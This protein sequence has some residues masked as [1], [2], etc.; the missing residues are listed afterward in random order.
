MG[1]NVAQSDGNEQ[2][3]MKISFVNTD[4][5]TTTYIDSTRFWVSND[6]ADGVSYNTAIQGVISGSYLA[7][8]DTL[9][10]VD[11]FGNYV[12]DFFSVTNDSLVISV[13][14][15]TTVGYFTKN[16]AV[17]SALAFITGTSTKFIAKSDG[18]GNSYTARANYGA[19]TTGVLSQPIDFTGSVKAD[20]INNDRL[21]SALYLGNAATANVTHTP[22]TLGLKFNKSASSTLATDD[23][24]T[25][26]VRVYGAGSA[27]YG[28]GTYF[29]KGMTRSTTIKRVLKAS[30]ASKLIGTLT[31]A[32]GSQAIVNGNTV[33]GLSVTVKDIFGDAFNAQT[34]GSSSL[35]SV[36]FKFEYSKK[37]TVDA[38]ITGQLQAGT[39]AA[40]S[41]KTIPKA[42]L[43]GAGV[44]A[45]NSASPYGS[46]LYSGATSSTG[47]YSITAKYIGMTS[48]GTTA[49]T[50]ARDSIDIIAYAKTNGTADTIRIKVTPGSPVYF[51]LDSLSAKL[52]TTTLVQGAQFP[53]S[54]PIFA[55]D[56][57]YNRITNLNL[58]YNTTFLDN[59]T[60]QSTAMKSINFKIDGRDPL[61]YAA[62]TKTDSIRI[63]S[64]GPIAGTRTGKG[65]GA[66]ALSDSSKIW[67][68]TQARSDSSRLNLG[69]TGA[70]PMGMRLN[71]TGSNYRISM[72]WNPADVGQT[73]AERSQDLGLF[74]LSAASAIDSVITVTQATTA[75]AGK[76]DT[77]VVSF[78]I[79]T[80]SSQSIGPNQADSLLFIQFVNMTSAAGIPS[81]INKANV[82]ISVDGTNYYTA[83]GVTQGTDNPDSIWVATP[84]LADAGTSNATVYVKIEGFVSPTIADTT[85]YYQVVVS[86]ESAPIKSHKY[87]TVVANSFAS[88]KILSPNATKSVT[89]P[90][91]LSQVNTTSLTDTLKAG[92]AA[93]FQIYTGDA[94]GNAVNIGSAATQ[95]LVVKHVDSTVTG[96]ILKV[97][98]TFDG[99]ALTTK[100]HAWYDTVTVKID[101]NSAGSYKLIDSLLVTPAMS[102]NYYIVVTDTNA[103]PDAMDSVMVHV[104]TTLAGTVALNPDTTVQ[105]ARST[106]LPTLTVTLR[107]TMGNLLADTLVTMKEQ[108]GDAAG[109]F[110][111]INDSTLSAVTDSVGVKASASGIATAIYKAG[112]GD[113]VSVKVWVLNSTKVTA[114]YY[115]AR[116]TLVSAGE[117][118]DINF[119][120]VPDS[121]V[122]DTTNA[123]TITVDLL[124]GEKVKKAYLT[125]YVSTL[126]LGTDMKFVESD[127]IMTL[128]ADSSNVSPAADSVRWTASIA[129]IKTVGT[130]IGYTVSAI[131]N[132]D[133]TTTSAM[134]HFIIA[135]K[136]GKRNISTSAV[137]VA[138]VMRSVYLVAGV[139]P[140]ASVTAVDYLGLDLDQSGDFDTPDLTAILAI[141]RG[142]GTLLASAGEQQAV[143]AKV[144]L[145]YV[146]TDKSNANLSVNLENSGSLNVA[147]LRIKYDT[148]KFVLGE[149]VATDR[150]KDVSVVT[151]NN[152]A[153][154]VYSIV[155]VNVNG[156]A[157]FKG[158]GA[159][160]TIPV[161]AVGDKFDGT[162]EISLLKAGFDDN[163]AA[164]LDRNVLSPKAVLPKAYALSQNYPNPFNPSTT[165]AFDVPE[166]KE[167]SV[168]LN[169]Y[170]MRGQLVRTLVS[171][172]KSEGSYQIQW[173]GDDNYGRKVS[174]GVYFYRIVAGEFSQTRKMV[175]LK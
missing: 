40:N 168:R 134:G 142:T 129:A 154:G 47:A 147:V 25:F 127:A 92:V 46:W 91:W 144:D 139:V 18:S 105:G 88:I 143:T 76:T 162:G 150:L 122:A 156:R 69:G 15:S 50:T 66:S 115:V 49:D 97:Q 126:T 74:S 131:D 60:V 84:I 137:N 135:P 24:V 36:G 72:I 75:T 103:V 169:V 64:L 38:T 125:K 128:V 108:Y 82:K 19:Q 102:G 158:S 3:K 56:T 7:G 120:T 93:K 117:A 33:T 9:I 132:T 81:G 136:R 32:G 151:S 31:L 111:Q 16:T 130:R 51:D 99:A 87:M 37:K 90:K 86:T 11:R 12:S 107:D 52:A 6:Y 62:S 85:N 17:G 68:L 95:G 54:I 44:L 123:Q 98:Q 63:D 133:D 1:T 109:G 167:V 55:L 53:A 21:A 106:N 174:S 116:T 96:K 89:I 100:T 119:V 110:V 80:G 42:R 161:T 8:A 2:A 124:D 58:D 23:T 77:L 152:T 13:S 145:A 41:V 159:I 146:A 59:V 171:E 39:K 166:G 172:V 4:Q 20:S 140:T 78:V 113:S 22:G 65:F 79:P 141:W 61:G 67:D 27:R 114:K 160:L 14:D 45:D 28:G 163:V 149:A 26:T 83:L 48:L 121:L 57:A 43:I 101:T 157:I 173:N 71:Y 5:S 29:N 30:S 153:E 138:D 148:E 70:D 112:T 94:Y 118:T 10:V 35:D 164:E 165:I 73:Y 104:N 34:F 175:I 155:V 170:N